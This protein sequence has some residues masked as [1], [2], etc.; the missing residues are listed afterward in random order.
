MIVLAEVSDK[1]PAEWMIP[2]FGITFGLPIYFAARHGWAIIAWIQM[3][4]FA[5]LTYG[6][7]NELYFDSYI[8][9]SI[10]TEFGYSYILLMVTTCF[11]PVIF[12]AVGLIRKRKSAA[13]KGVV[14]TGDPLRGSPAAHP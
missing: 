8:R 11:I 6:L 1:V 7:A 5:L 13:N 9:E 10:I 14:L 12:G 3:G 2:L 4:I